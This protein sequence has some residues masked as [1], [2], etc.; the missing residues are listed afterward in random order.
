VLV[1]NAE[2]CLVLFWYWS[3][4]WSEHAAHLPACL[5]ACVLLLLLLLTMHETIVHVDN[6]DF[7]CLALLAAVH[8]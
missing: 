4:C 3:T 7:K 6:A 1:I 5:P 8:A 2:P